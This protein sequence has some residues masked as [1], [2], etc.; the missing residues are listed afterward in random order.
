M[1]NADIGKT[2]YLAEAGVPLMIRKL[3]SVKD[4]NVFRIAEG[5]D[6]I[7]HGCNQE[8]YPRR[9]Q[10]LAGCGPTTATNIYLYLTSPQ[11]APESEFLQHT[12][13]SSVAQMQEL[14]KYVTPSFRGVNTTRM[15][16]E[17]MLEYAQTKGLNVA[18]R[19]LEVPKDTAERPKFSETLKFVEDGLAA[20]TPL[21]FL[22]LDN[23]QE[24]NLDRWHWV[25]IIGLEYEEDGS[26]AY[27]DILDAGLIKRIN[28]KL[29]YETTTLGGGLIYFVRS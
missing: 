18:Y 12:L 14:W 5:T 2:L 3:I 28:F 21:A 8:W 25:T 15:F 29:W 23:G 17:P 7:H 10:R 16:Y 11:H 19:V 4:L 22:N 20:N 26:S 6:R 13:E 1:E 27:A 24:K 9:L